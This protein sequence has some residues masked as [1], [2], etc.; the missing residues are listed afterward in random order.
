MALS[1]ARGKSFLSALLR[2]SHLITEAIPGMPGDGSLGRTKGLD[3]KRREGAARLTRAHLA[4][5]WVEKT[6]SASYAALSGVK[7][8]SEA[9]FPQLQG[10]TPPFNEGTWF[11]ISYRGK[12]HGERK[13]GLECC[14]A[15]VLCCQHR[16]YCSP[17]PRADAKLQTSSDCCLCV[18]DPGAGQHRPH[19]CCHNCYGTPGEEVQGRSNAQREMLR[20]TNAAGG[21]WGKDGAWHLPASWFIQ[22]KKNV[23]VEFSS[24]ALGEQVLLP[25]AEWGVLNPCM[26]SA[27]P[28]LS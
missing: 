28:G 2:S 9:I 12:H 17:L 11:V 5:S 27:G 26:T 4:A 15:P 7:C 8:S 20:R 19:C 24:T 23:K 21:V 10:Q 1:A 25:S 13:P 6:K 14:Q 3:P 18:S 16:T 22:L